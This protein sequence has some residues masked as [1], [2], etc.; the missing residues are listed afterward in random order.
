MSGRSWIVVLVLIAGIGWW[1]SPA[2]PHAGDAPET[3]DGLPITCTMPLRV[4]AFESPRQTPVPS[5]QTPFRLEAATLTPLAGFSVDARVL[6]RKDY[7]SDREANLSP[8][9]LALGWGAMRNEAIL[10]RLEISQ[11]GR[12][13]H[14]R[15]SGDAPLPPAEIA[16]SSANMHM[17][18]ANAAVAEALDDVRE[19]E[20]VRI[21][22]W[23][24]EATTPEGWRWRSSTSRTDTGSGACELVYVCALTRL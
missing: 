4:E 2:A 15:W 9:D 21:D 6:S 11:S 17:I 24:V 14:Y 7:R 8:T 5:T 18:P 19:G 22:G 16:H 13:Y 3:A 12:W 10:S 23:L 20:R 1:F